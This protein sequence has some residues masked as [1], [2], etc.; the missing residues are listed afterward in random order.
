MGYE[1]V[2]IDSADTHSTNDSGSSVD[3]K[4][5]RPIN[6]ATSVEVVSATMKND[7][8]N[9]RE[10]ENAFGIMFKAQDDDGTPTPNILSLYEL[11]NVTAMINP[12][13]DSHLIQDAL[14]HHINNG[15]YGTI[16]PIYVTPGV[17]TIDTLCDRLTTLITAD[18]FHPALNPGTTA[19]GNGL[20]FTTMA[21]QGYKTVVSRAFDASFDVGSKDIAIQLVTYASNAREYRNSI[22]DRMGFQY[23][24]QAIPM[25]YAKQMLDIP[26]IDDNSAMISTVGL[27]GAKAYHENHSHMFLTSN[28]V[29]GDIQRTYTTNTP[30]GLGYTRQ[31]EILQVIQVDANMYNYIHFQSNGHNALKHMIH[32]G[33]SISTFNLTLTDENG[34]KFEDGTHHP[35]Q[36][37]IRFEVADSEGD[38]L[39]HAIIEKNRASAFKS[40]HMVR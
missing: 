6:N 5:T 22:L 8:F 9:V 20:I 24:E 29:N 32:T 28:L 1:Y 4:L 7:F 40:R 27:V 11:V 15:D 23:A 26:M 10:G 17:Y 37:V 39:S 25:E 34:R 33:R 12:M 18:Q 3:I 38:K 13:D 31:S 35:F 36:V 19:A 16:L 21:D 30:G 2:F 14:S